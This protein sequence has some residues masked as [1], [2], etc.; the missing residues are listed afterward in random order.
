MV[1]K[2]WQWEFEAVGH[3]ASAVGKQ[4]EMIVGTQLIFALL[5]FIQSRSQ[6][7]G[8]CCPLKLDLCSSVKPANSLKDLP[9][10]NIKASQ[11]RITIIEV[12]STCC[13]RHF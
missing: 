11:S 3:I 10:G 8:C 5:T 13:N 12:T 6:P 2:G 7:L 1:G 9:R 4:E